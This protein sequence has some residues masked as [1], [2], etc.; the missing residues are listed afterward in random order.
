MDKCYSLNWS[1]SFLSFTLHSTLM[2]DTQLTM[3]K[4]IAEVSLNKKPNSLLINCNKSKRLYPSCPLLLFHLASCSLHAFLLT[5]SQSNEHYPRVRTLTS[6]TGILLFVLPLNFQISIKAQFK[7]YY[8]P[9]SPLLN[10]TTLKT[11]SKPM[12]KKPHVTCLAQVSFFLIKHYPID[13][14]YKVGDSVLRK[15]L[16]N[17]P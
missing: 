5:V 3:L 8:S 7:I 11:D 16:S 17:F 1:A 14:I 9:E 6:P 2:T 12:T 13:H 10:R 4:F 15:R